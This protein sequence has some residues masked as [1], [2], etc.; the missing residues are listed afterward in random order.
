VINNKTILQYLLEQDEEDT[1]KTFEDDPTGFILKKY[2]SLNT[3]LTELMTSSFR[4][5]IQEIFIVAPKPTTFKVVLNNGQHIFLTYMGP[6]YE[7]TV[8]GKNYYLM[9]IG[10]KERCM[11]AISKLLRGGSPISNKGPEGAEQAADAANEGGD[12][13]PLGDTGGEAEAGAGEENLTEAKKILVAILKKGK[14]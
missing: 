7:A 8:S 11:L 14:I 9:N 6:A 3:I 10:E 2:V 4:E 5:Y 13:A 1:P 12:E